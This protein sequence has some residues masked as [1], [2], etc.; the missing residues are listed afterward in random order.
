MMT[1]EE[2]KKHN[3]KVH[4]FIISLINKHFYDGGSFGLLS[5]FRDE[6][7]DES[8]DRIQCLGIDLTELGNLF[9]FIKGLWI[10]DGRYYTNLPINND[11]PIYEKRSVW[12]ADITLEQLG[13]LAVK[14]K[15]KKFVFG[16]EGS[17]G[18]YYLDSNGNIQPE[19]IGAKYFAV[20]I[21]NSGGRVWARFSCRYGALTLEQMKIQKGLKECENGEE[22]CFFHISNI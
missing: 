4:A 16:E 21:D 22:K 15:Q 13:S 1:K 12:I 18:L 14:Y 2:T 3:E 10:L 11:V 19:I 17:F 20:E 6:F 7:S 8:I 5:T 9:Y